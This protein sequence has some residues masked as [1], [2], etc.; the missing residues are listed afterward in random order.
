MDH[1]LYINLN[2]RTD[3]K[4]HVERQLSLLGL[5]GTRMPAILHK[6]GALGCIMSHIKCL[7]HAKLHQWKTICIMEDDITFTNIEVFKTS[8][9]HVSTNWDVLLLGTNMAPPFE[10]IDE[11]HARVFNAQTTTGYIV[12]EHYYDTLLKNY[13]ESL[14]L[15][16]KFQIKSLYAID[17]Y[18]KRLQ[19][20]DQWYVLTPLT[21][22]QLPGYSDIENGYADYSRAM[23]AKKDML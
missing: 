18:W 5:T 4:K 3:R 8:L 13:Q 12:K 20:N 11:H 6:Q 17:I 14:A 1:I 2:H 23:L 22:V 16:T 15:F 9:S 10:Q 21:V 7:E 19:K